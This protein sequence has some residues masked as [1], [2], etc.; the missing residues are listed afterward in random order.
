M[1]NNKIKFLK[2]DLIVYLLVLLF[3]IFISFFWES[4][5]LPFSE[6]N[7]AESFLINKKINPNTDTL[8][9]VLFVG[10]PLLLY[11]MLN[12]SI[13]YNKINFSLKE[14]NNYIEEGFFDYK[15]C[16]AISVLCLFI[17]I[18]YKAS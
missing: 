1:E 8:R 17:I 9:Y 4:I 3:T 2:K 11:V 16:I 12:S 5:S 13:Q 15:V 14:T 10:L 7:Y 18:D 6:I